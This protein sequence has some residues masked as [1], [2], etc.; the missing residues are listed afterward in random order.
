MKR[1]ILAAMFSLA[2]GIVVGYKLLWPHVVSADTRSVLFCLCCALVSIAVALCVIHAWTDSRSRWGNT[3]FVG[4][5]LLFF[6][7]TG[8]ARYV[9]YAFDHDV[10]PSPDEV[11]VLGIVATPPSTHGARTTF[12]IE[13]PSRHAR[14]MQVSVWHEGD[15]LWRPP[16]IGDVATLKGRVCR[17][18]NLG[19]PDEYD[20]ASWLWGQ[21]VGATVHVDAR[22]LSVRRAPPDMVGRLP[23]LWRLRLHALE[24]RTRLGQR[25][26]ATGLDERTL[27]VV[28]AVTL[29]DRSGITAEMRDLYAEAGASHLL[30]LSGLHLGV[31]LGV[32]LTLVYNVLV[33]SPWRIP[34]CVVAVVFTWGFT[35]VAGLP[36]SLVRAAVMTTVALTAAVLDRESPPLHHLVLTAFV[37]LLV[38]PMYLFDVGVQMSMAAVAGILLV[39]RPFDLWL[40]QHVRYVV[41]TLERYWL[42]WPFR[43][44]QISLSA[45]MFTLPLSALYF[46]RLTLYGPL[47]SVVLVPL[48][49]AIIYLALLLLAVGS[50]WPWLTSLLAWCVTRMVTLQL[51]VMQVVASWPGSVVNDFWSKKARRELVVYN[52]RGCPALHVI[53]TPAESSLLMPYPER[54]QTGLQYVAST[55]WQRRLTARPKILSGI[56]SLSVGDLRVVMLS[57]PL[58]VS[59]RSSMRRAQP[60]AETFGTDVLWLCGDFRGDAEDLGL[61]F[62]PRLVVLDASLPVALRQRLRHGLASCG[63]PVYDV[64]ERGALRVRF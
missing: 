39:S 63:V 51:D 59:G 30:A 11:C 31:I 45:Q 41:F 53:A 42:F 9:L 18:R 15:S 54:A 8:T 13:T 62:A 12:L 56:R 46:H 27:A 44:I 57:S 64:A 23:L 36:T 34:V 55:F 19:N 17:P 40:M 10:Q 52:N 7:L 37:M 60:Q 32:L 43:L 25:F 16:A 49:T 21:G 38:N 3:V 14:R 24:L 48:T 2:V 61:C 28:T 20:Y 6:V 33:V 58:Y 26:A 29:A 50:V 47:A 35:F 4:T 5:T 1:P 22:R